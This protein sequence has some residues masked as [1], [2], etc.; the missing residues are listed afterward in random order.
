MNELIVVG[1]HGPDWIDQCRASLSQH[2]PD[3]KVLFVETGEFTGKADATIDGGWSTGAY[4]WAVEQHAAYDRFLFIQDS[5]TALADPLPWFRDQWT[6]AGAVAWQ[7]FPMQWD[8][9]DQRRAV[10]DRYESRPSHGIFGPVFYTD[11]ASL[12]NLAA[13]GLTPHLPHNRIGAQGTER[14]WAYAYAQAGLPVAGL[15]WNATAMQSENGY[16]PF[17][18]VFANRP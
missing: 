16:G 4:L 8:S 3:A 1:C 7:V 15:P 18:K 5:M 12:D 10:E 11:R 13:L 6:G 9:D 2:S 17:R 14:A